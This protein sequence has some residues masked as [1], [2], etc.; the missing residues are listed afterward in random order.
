MRPRS[1]ALTLTVSATLLFVGAGL[2]I[3]ALAAPPVTATPAHAAAPDIAV[4]NVQAHL[5]QL[6]TIATGNGGTRRSG[7]AG[8]TASVAYIKGK[9]QAAGYTVTEQTCTSCT[10]RANNL[11]A[12]WPGGPADQ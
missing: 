7:T 12:D 2:A 6:G 1:A 8:Y 9:L 5:A 4:A 10:Y 11:I 3:P